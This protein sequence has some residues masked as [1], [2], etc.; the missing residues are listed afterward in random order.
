VDKKPVVQDP[1]TK[2]KERHA[3]L[4]KVLIHN[5]P[6]TPM[7]F[8]VSVLLKVFNLQY[9]K[10]VQIM[11]EAHKTEIALVTVETLERA[12]FHV[13]QCKSLSGARGFPLSLTYEP[14]D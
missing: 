11:M 12:E 4:Y 7:D 3:P 2:P 10:A 13:E 5:D 9:E 8:V 1:V 6:F 14:E